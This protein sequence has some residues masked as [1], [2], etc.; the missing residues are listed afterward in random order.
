ML[1]KIL[2]DFHFSAKCQIVSFDGDGDPRGES[3][4]I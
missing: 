4:T 2:V 1:G 3:D